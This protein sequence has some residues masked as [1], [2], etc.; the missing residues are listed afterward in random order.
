MYSI[1]WGYIWETLGKLIL[2]DNYHQLFNH[3]YYGI[4]CISWLLI[5]DLTSEKTCFFSYGIR[6]IKYDIS[7][8]YRWQWDFS[9]HCDD[10]H[11]L[12]STHWELLVSWGMVD[13]GRMAGFF[14]DGRMWFQHDS[15]VHDDQDFMGISCDIWGLSV[16]L[17]GFHAIFGKDTG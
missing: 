13:D 9:D 11:P 7:G 2:Q 8:I 1:L 17:W 3:Q 15:C 4:F 5:A 12:T 16:K 14:P 6:S 10:D